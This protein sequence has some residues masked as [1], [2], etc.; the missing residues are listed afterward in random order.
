MNDFAGPAARQREMD[1]HEER[2]KDERRKM[3]T[4]QM[5]DAEKQSQQEVS[6]TYKGVL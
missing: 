5:I 6:N 4:Q 1:A 2:Q 3:I